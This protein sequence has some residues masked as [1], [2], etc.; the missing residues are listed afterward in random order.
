MPYFISR[1]ELLFW[2]IKEH[3]FLP[4]RPRLR[5]LFSKVG[6]MPVLVRQGASWGYG[7]GLFSTVGWGWRQRRRFRAI[8]PQSSKEDFFDGFSVPNAEPQAVKLKIVDSVLNVWVLANSQGK[9]FVYMH[10]VIDRN[11]QEIHHS[12][13]TFHPAYRGGGNAGKILGSAIK[14]Y[15]TIELD[16]ITLLAGLSGGGAHWAKTGFLPVDGQ[17]ALVK[18]CV[19]TNL[20]DIDQMSLDR[21]EQSYGETLVNSIEEIFSSQR[22]RWMWELRDLGASVPIRIKKILLGAVLL[23]NSRWDGYLDLHDSRS[24]KRLDLYVAECLRKG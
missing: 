13:M 8:Y 15:K 11:R 12:L 19:L 16:R 18:A 3:R 21:Y 10:R 14:F 2:S 7:R 1:L 20:A 6:K 22:P 17:A 4:K 9:P 5:S 23:M 24:M